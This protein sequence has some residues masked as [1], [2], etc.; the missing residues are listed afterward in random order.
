MMMASAPEHFGENETALEYFQARAKELYAF[1]DQFDV[2]D[3]SGMIEK[4][5]PLLKAK[6]ID[7]DIITHYTNVYNWIIESWESVDVPLVEQRVEIDVNGYDGTGAAQDVSGHLFVNV[8]KDDKTYLIDENG[9]VVGEG[10]Q[11]IINLFMFQNDLYFLAKKEGRNYIVGPENKVIVEGCQYNATYKVIDKQLY[12]RTTVN[13]YAKTYRPQGELFNGKFIESDFPI[14][15]NGLLYYP[16]G[17]EL[18]ALIVDGKGKK[19]S[20]EHSY[21]SDIFALSKERICYSGSGDKEDQ[22]YLMEIG[23]EVPLLIF[24][25]IRERFEMGGQMM[26]VVEKDLEYFVVD[27]EGNEKTKRYAG[28]RD[29]KVINGE[30]YFFEVTNQGEQLIGPKEK[31]VGEPGWVINAFYNFGNKLFYIA[32]IE[33]EAFIV[34]ANNNKERVVGS[35]SQMI[36]LGGI[37]FYFSHAEKKVSV[38]DVCGNEITQKYDSIGSCKMVDEKHFYVMGKQGDKIVKHYYQIEQD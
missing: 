19:V 30:L 13:D 37:P 36:E 18:N 21:I 25:E 22:S 28:I 1:F 15:I 4:M 20:K 26:F 6:K 9:K 38:R 32:K 12:I 14:M 31:P 10:Y 8:F 17:N 29:L 7:L 34:D 23:S 2:D 27:I 3:W 5:S 24:D 11:E 33:G 35:L 16:V